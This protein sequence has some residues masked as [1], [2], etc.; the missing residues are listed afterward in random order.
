MRILHVLANLAPRY[1]GPPQACKDMAGAVAGLGHEVSIYTTNQ[2]GPTEL[3]V[4]LDRPV[5]EK[6]VAIRFFPI[7]P[8]RFWGT[9][10]PLARALREKI[11]EVDLVHLHSLYLF[12]DLVTGHLCRQYGIPYLLQ[13]HGALDPRIYRRHRRRKTVLE[14]LFENRNLKN[15]AAIFF[16]S[17]EEKILAQPFTSGTPGLVAPLGLNLSDYETV[18]AW[19]CFRARFP[20]I[21]HR[22]IILFLGRI[23]FIKGLDLLV[24][25]FA[26]LAREGEDVQLV[27][28]GPDD[29]GWG[30]KVRKWA[31]EEKVLER[32]TFPGLLLGEDKLA[33]LQEAT[34]L[35]LP[36][37]AESFG[38]AAVEALACGLP[39][40][41]SDQVK[42]WREVARAQAGLVIGGDASQLAAALRQLLHDPEARRR[43]GE[44]G[45]RLVATTFSWDEVAKKLSRM[46]QEVLNGRN[47]S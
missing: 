40:V 45:K 37:Y 30:E 5:W 21:G 34:V 32:V 1:G 13:P 3:Q 44:N 23:N 9:S 24:Q 8:P 35:A 28:A 33:V 20:E 11:K 15:A 46:Y 42:I 10:L 36:S 2:D 16:S 31:R 39:V 25:A 29:D 27:L 6:G 4:P 12:H 18:P 47:W 17:E 38:L 14:V 22:K 41:I 19:G 26:A 7:Q 43:M